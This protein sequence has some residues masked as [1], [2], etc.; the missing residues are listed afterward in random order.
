MKIMKLQ[1]LK[2]AVIGLFVAHSSFSLADGNESLAALMRGMSKDQSVVSAPTKVANIADVSD[3]MVRDAV[4]RART[5]K[6]FVKEFLS[7]LG[8]I[9]DNN[10]TPGEYT[11]A[12][13][14]TLTGT[15]L[16]GALDKAH[17]ILNQLEEKLTG[18]ETA[19]Q[20]ELAKPQ[21][22]R[23]LSAV[24]TLLTEIQAIMKSGHTLFK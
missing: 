5:L 23:D 9:N 11:P 16:T 12:S 17:E 7:G 18:I 24:R 3:D 1:N 20:T 2:M 22:N 10:F 14:L 19:Y 6:F 8:S 15:E 13:L 21:A 4:L